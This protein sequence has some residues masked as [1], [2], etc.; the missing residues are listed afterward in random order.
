V[1]AGPFRTSASTES[2][3]RKGLFIV[4]TPGRE[5]EFLTAL[6]AAGA[7]VV[8]FTTGLGAP[9]G[10]PFMPVIKITGN[11]STYRRLLGHMDI[12]IPTG[13]QAASDAGT[14]GRSIL[15]EALAVASGK[16]TKAEKAGYGNFP[17]IFTIGPTI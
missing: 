6:A 14:M 4:D 12:L 17:N 1:V 13:T 7:Q 16:R 3:F 9:Q 5:P 15:D 10:F 8:A 2:D 11:P